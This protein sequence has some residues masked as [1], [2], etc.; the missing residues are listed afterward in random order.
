MMSANP[1]ITEL[2][3]AN[4]EAYARARIDAMALG[5]GLIKLELTPDG[6]LRAIRLDPTATTI[7]DLTAEAAPDNMPANMPAEEERDGH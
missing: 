5:T 6:L 4:R 7:T 2:D 3:A 1:N